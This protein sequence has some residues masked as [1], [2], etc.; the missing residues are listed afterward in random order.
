MK[1]LLQVIAAC[2]AKGVSLSVDDTGTG[3]KLKGNIAA[4]TSVEKETLRN[5]KAAVISLLQQ[6]KSV[7][8]EDI[9][10]A[11]P[12]ASWELSSAQ[13]RMWLLSQLEEGSAAYNIPVV[14]LFEGTLRQDCLQLAFLQL[15]E[16]H[17][18]LRAVFREDVAGEAKQH[19][20]SVEDAAF[21]IETHDL[22]GVDNSTAWVHSFVSQPFQ[23]SEGPL[24]RACICELSDSRRIFCLVMHHIISDGWSLDIIITELMLLYVAAC[25]GRTADMPALS[26]QYKDYATWQQRKIGTADFDAHRLYWTDLFSGELPVLSFP[27]DKPRPT[28]K[29]YKG[30]MV[31][32]RI[33]AHITTRLKSLLIAEDSTLFVGLLS[34]VNLLLF[35][36]TGQDDIITGTPVSGRSR[37]VL[38]NQVGLYLNTLALRTRLNSQDGFLSLLRHVRQM[39]LES[40]RHQDYPFDMLTEELRLEWDRSRNPLFDVMMILRNNAVS[41]KEAEQKLAGL[42]I[43]E[44]EGGQETF[45]KFDLS[46]NFMEIGD[47]I[48]MLVTYNS[49]IYTP[50]TA[51]RTGN[52]LIQLLDAAL[53]T[54]HTPISLL[55]YLTATEQEQLLVSFNNMQ[56]ACTADETIVDLFEEQALRTPT[57]TAVVYKEDTL[58][59][60][61]LNRRATLVAQ[62]L[63][64]KYQLGENALVGILLHRSADMIVAILGILKAGAAYVP[65]DPEYPVSRKAFILKDT[66]VKVLLTAEDAFDAAI[67]FTG[68]TFFISGL[69]AAVQDIPVTLLRPQQ[70]SLAYVIYTSGSTGEPKGVMITHRSLMDYCDGIRAV[71][72]IDACRTF[73]L[74][75]TIAADLGNTV[76]FPALLTG[77]ALQIYDNDALLT[78]EKIFNGDLDC[79]K[80]VPSHWM[81]LQEESHCYLP[82]K[83]LIF[84]G[85]QLTSNVVSFISRGN[86]TCEVYNHYGPSETTIGKLLKRVELRESVVH[87]PLGKPFCRSAFYIL[88]EAGQLQP[89]GVAGEICI[90]GDGL[91]KGYL[92]RPELTNTRFLP[93]PFME[94]ERMYKTGDVGRWL[95]NGCIEFMGRTDDQVK[96]RGYRIELGEIEAAIRRHADV[97]AAVVLTFAGSTGE[98]QLVAYIVDND[99]LSI[100]ALQ[101]WLSTLLPAYMIPAHFIRIPAMPL[102]LN[103]K[104]DRKRL[105]APEENN[106]VSAIEYIAPRTALEEQLANIWRGLLDKEKISVKDN[107]FLLGG[108][109]LKATRLLSSIRRE[110]QV[111]LPLKTLFQYMVLEEQAQL[112]A[113]AV[114]ETHQRITAAPLQEDYPL[115]SAQRRFWILSQFPDAAAAYHMP[116]IYQLQGKVDTM[117]LNA[118]FKGMVD[119]HE[120]LRT[121]FREDASGNIRQMIRP[122]EEIFPG[123][124]YEEVGEMPLQERIT[125]FVMQAF[126][127]TDGPLLRVA[128]Y[129]TAPDHFVLVY[130]MHHIISDG[131]SMGLLLKELLSRYYSL[132]SGAEPVPQALSLQYKDYAWWQ[133]QQLQHSMTSAR[134]FWMEQLSGELPVIN[135]PTDRLRPAIKT[136]Q[137]SVVNKRIPAAL[138]Q[139]LKG[140]VAMHDA[141]LFMGLLS[142]V[143]TLLY[144]YTGQQ[145]VITG[146]PVAGREHADLEDQLGLYLNTL[147]LR[148]QLDGQGSYLELLQTVRRITLDAYSHQSYPFEELVNDLKLPADLSRSP[149][150]DVM[151]ILQN[152]GSHR[153]MAPEMLGGVSISQ[154]DGDA[155]VRS[156]FDLTFSF[157]EVGQELDLY[158]EYNTDI[159]D[160]TTIQQLALHFI[161]LLDALLHAPHARIDLIDY[162]SAAEKKILTI[163]FN[164]TRVDYPAH[165]S[166]LQLLEKQAA[167]TPDAVALSCGDSMLTYRELHET[168]NRFAAFLHQHYR[169]TAGDLA[170]V[171]L[172]RDEWLIIALLGVLKTGAAYVPLDPDY[173]EE[174]IRYMMEDSRSLVLIDADVIAAFRAVANTFSAAEHSVVPASD[175]PAYLIYTSGSTGKPKGVVIT[176]LNVYTF[177]CWCLEEFALDEADVVLGVTSVC[178]DLSIF[179]IFYT[180]SSGKRLL[181]LPN[182][183][184]VPGCMDTE[185]RLLLNTVPGVVGQLLAAGTD[186]RAV[187]VLNMAGE[188]LPASVAFAD[189]LRQM[190]VRNLYGPSEDTTYSTVFRIGADQRI[191]IGR[192]IANTSVFIVSAAG[193]LQPIG[194]IGEI[195]ISGDGLA[196]GYLYRPELTAE[197]FVPNPFLPGQRMYKTGDL[198]RWLPDGNLEFAGRK[199]D[200]VKIRGYRIEPGEIATAIRKYPGVESAV[201]APRTNSQGEKF[202]A[203]YLVSDNPVDTQAL[204]TYL[205]KLL[206]H[207]MVP[208]CYM[209]LDTMPMTLNGKIDKK[210]LPAVEEENRTAIAFEAPRTIVEKQLA[211]IWHVLLETGNIGL[212]DNF[213]LHGGHSLK[214]IRLQ[215]QIHKAFQV[216]LDVPALFRHATLE[217]QARLIA[218]AAQQNYQTI[219]PLEEQEDYL[220][221][222]A[223]RRFWVLGQFP[224]AGAAYHMSG[225][226]ELDGEPDIA[227]LNH[228]FAALINRYEILRSIFREREDGEVRQVIQSADRVFRGIPVIEMEHQ[229]EEALAAA[230][231]KEVNRPFDLSA[232]PLLRTALYHTRDEKYVL[233]YVMHHII[234]DGWSVGIMLRE[235]ILLYNSFR[236]GVGVALSPLKLQYRDYAAWQQSRLHEEIGADRNWW[237]QQLSGSL[238]VLEMPVDAPRPALKTYNGGGVAMA[239]EAEVLQQLKAA[240]GKEG[241]TLFM[242]LLTAVYVLLHRYSG[243]EDIIIGSPVAGRNHADLEGQLGLFLNTLPLRMQVNPT[244][245]FHELLEQVRLLTLEAFAHQQYPFEELLDDLQ[246]APDLS[247]S[248]LFD[249]MLVLQNNENGFMNDRLQAG[250]ISIS[251]YRTRAVTKSRFDLTFSFVEV[252]GAL[253]AH[254]EYNS[255]IWHVATAERIMAHLYRIITCM[256]TAPDSI[257]GRMELLS[258][259]ETEQQLQQFN[260]TIT[261]YPADATISQLFAF[262][263][264]AK[265]DHIALSCNGTS[266][267]YAALNIL[268]NRFAH[269]LLSL[270]EFGKNSVVAIQLDKGIPMMTAILGVLKCGAAYMPVDP[271][272]PQERVNYMMADSGCSLLITEDMM[273]A[274]EEQKMMYDSHHPV[275]TAAAQDVAYVMYTSGSTGKPKG[276]MVEHRSV[277]RLVKG[278]QYVRLHDRDVLLSTGAVAFDATT[279]EYWGM[280]LN[281]GRLV[282]CPQ[283]T[284]SDTTYLLHLIRTEGVTMMWFTAG[285]FHQ[286]IEYNIDIF[287][288]L[289]TV[290][291]GGDRLSPLHVGK[292]LHAYPSLEI[293][294]GYGPTEN[295]T[296]SLTCRMTGDMK[297]IPIGRPISNSTVY[298]LDDH[299][300]LL[301]LGA[302]GE[303]CVGGD[304]LARGYIASPELTATRFI[305][306]PFLPGERIYKTGDLG[307]WLPDGNVCFL[308]RKDDQVKIRGYRIEPG[309]IEN[310]LTAYPQVEAALVMPV[311]DAAGDKML[312]AYLAGDARISRDELHQYLGNLLP[313]FML[314]DHYVFLEQFPLTANGKVDRHALPLPDQ[315]AAAGKTYVAPRNVTEEKLQGVWQEVL[316]REVISVTDD[317][318]LSGG[319]SLKANR[320]ILRIYKAFGVKM[321]IKELFAHPKLSEQAVWIDHAQG[322]GFSGIPRAPHQED[323]PLSAAQRRIWVLSRFD[324]ANIAYNVPFACV[325]EG[326]LD[327]AALIAALNKL[328]EKHESLRTV[329]RENADGLVRQV[330]L[331]AEQ[332]IVYPEYRDMRGNAAE[333][334]LQAAAKVAVPFDLAQGP[335]QRVYLW[336]LE[337][338]K[339]LLLYV[340]HHI[341]SDG[342]S[343]NVWIKEL[344]EQYRQH[345]HRPEQPA[346]LPLQYKDYAVWQQKQLD[347]TAG[348]ASRQYWLDQFSGDIP[349][350]DFPSDKIRPSV[351]TYR[352]AIVNTM[353]PV[354]CVMRLEALCLEHGATL[355]MGITAIVNAL[356]YRYTGQEDIILGTPVAGRLHTDLEEQIG[357]YINTLALRTQFS[358][359][360]SFTTL[361]TQVVNTTLAALEH[362]D[363]PF[364]ELVNNLP[365]RHDM[366]RNAL[367]DVMVTL[368]NTTDA[369]AAPATPLLRIIPYNDNSL[370]PGNKF[371]LTFSFVQ[372]VAGALQVGIVYNT[373]LYTTELITALAFHLEQLTQA[374]VAS[375]DTAVAMMDMLSSEEKNKVAFTFNGNHRDYPVG[376]SIVS[377]FQEQ[378]AVAGK[379]PALL[380]G[381]NSMSYD[382]LNTYANRMAAYLRENFHIGKGHMV[383]INLPRNEWLI[384]AVLGVLKTGAAYVPLDPAYPEER[385]AYILEDSQCAL[386]LNESAMLAFTETAETYSGQNPLQLPDAGD[387][388]YLIYTSGSTGK[389]KG[390][391]IEHRN[392]Y[393]FI[394]WCLE[395]FDSSAFDTVFGVTSIC[396]DLSVFEIF[397]TLICGKKLRILDNALSIPAW[398]R[399]T[400]RILLNTVPG[401]VAGLLS[402]NIDLS[403]VSLLNVAGEPVP[404]HFLQDVQLKRMQVRNLYGPS[405]DT[406]YSTIYR[407]DNANRVLIGKPISNTSVHILNA[408]G[409]LQPV[410]VRGEIC[411]S[412]AGLARGYKNQPA[413]TAEKFTDHP[414]LP[415]IRMYRTGDIGSWTED[416]NIAFWGRKDDQVKIRGFRIEPGEIEKALLQLAMVSDALVVAR[417]ERQGDK[418]LV[419]YIVCNEIPDI[420]AMRAELRKTLPDYMIPAYFV[421]LPHFPLTASGKKD[422]SKLPD[423]QSQLDEPHLSIAPRNET[424]ERLIRIWQ[425]LLGKERIGIRDNF[426]EC[427]GH[428]L[429]LMQMIAKIQQQFSVQ[430][431]IPQVFKDPYI[432]HISD[433]ITFMLD[434]QQLKSSI[435]QLVQIDI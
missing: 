316:G 207:Y 428:S 29:T 133:Q 131:W 94:G 138:L 194:V 339:W 338:N 211:E 102:T 71:T 423:H 239:I 40:F 420:P 69:Q 276:V 411:I 303:I 96:I 263:A 34:A 78:P 353:I 238:P 209:Q 265:P 416:G 39:T 204:Q 115:S 27:T 97:L 348:E 382:T 193:A 407:L 159:F 88:S 260:Q 1:A 24:L 363:Y 229:D 58:S 293:I 412:G 234:S 388:A 427:G 196:K 415:G 120:I 377:M 247:R 22:R 26:I 146:S 8:E 414:F 278:Q 298:I 435:D 162:L 236:T 269:F 180:L 347:Q 297:D 192:P 227:A 137:G 314:P 169:L 394:C 399:T 121:V 370:L 14:K 337:N 301:P 10:P 105:P 292:L 331:P 165:T 364:D 33:P 13:R 261:P 299:H 221:S 19:F 122:A 91:A 98:K 294:N 233:V 48:E 152:T 413:L 391:M 125:A 308:G 155:G 15:L 324:E 167:T 54:P 318:F 417:P 188:T 248:P 43:C 328:T 224:E 332:A 185:E 93:N 18:I 100:P 214:V 83:C 361:L 266:L 80:I 434:Q 17:E 342:W 144:R 262:Q 89:V 231:A 7:A 432:E 410:G 30:G 107:F 112:I 202:L 59:Y 189:S 113:N 371:D 64:G 205:A 296:F 212:K 379:Q 313:S 409:Q 368:N 77:G 336:Q 60:A 25:E 341:I 135:L 396:F 254:L 268:A 334:S 141:T 317:F 349:V 401:V 206:P 323:Y 171:M 119:R 85:E 62:Q 333:A 161:Q 257:I 280:L 362:Q 289:K 365:L 44:Y 284:L 345:G 104:I 56:D 429:K 351:K 356:L 81:A 403:A 199:D 181:L 408:A 9:L 426:F 140:T 21:V 28:V 383:G 400:E 354:E 267:T 274:F 187:K 127:L 148:V 35:R 51:D 110:F 79:I 433:Q 281:G 68:E 184:S 271:T 422:K 300:A 63:R 357:C 404:P 272:F 147:A 118:A 397:Y 92:N 226:Y 31:Y 46:F 101:H 310:A 270:Q 216:R 311:T 178:F 153:I 218:A 175:D 230:I 430:L 103:G 235:L 208:G 129:N 73:G 421:Q 201:V 372:D 61:E 232:G 249:V 75:S 84:G 124:V 157:A 319:H 143:Y 359:T 72:N 369:A 47:E 406:T 179:E 302:T 330:V 378:V 279:F 392:A 95:E 355:F 182:A 16:R 195:C 380:F 264:T 315:E 250:D 325:L 132:Q 168:S 86:P 366:G 142:A 375:P 45:N 312:V 5:Q 183:L 241:N 393:A 419:A 130:V 329:F 352:G 198:G 166:I 228:A 320:L 425:E 82:A 23:L 203:A 219:T 150:F 111:A 76:L 259:V 395:E 340:T 37:T 2:R 149:L 134:A 374:A 20:L 305:P 173:P 197:K 160:H 390:V 36:Y 385:I 154:W 367:F 384:I 256:A 225:I 220:L 402:E 145:D 174:R 373:D 343:M 283:D 114:K 381:D 109:S 32:K 321:T 275:N 389:P 360:A 386:V 128:L 176:H 50:S 252:N 244:L 66:Q 99:R 6:A 90:S 258:A 136:Y 156:K 243:Q 344:F 295:T 255:D 405:E 108:H 240:G 11:A 151:V 398:L 106:I 116:G 286:L 291:A 327:E 213:F 55:S 139:K 158:L 358:G 245:S 49:D 57:A 237:M 52:H 172:S 287:S 53:M 273:T 3:L 335:L 191:L 67:D 277:L 42:T 170:A 346:L 126:S 12:Q 376:S 350:L 326:E 253:Q 223:Q 251:A 215:S 285:W 4:L 163:T 309:E 288:G 217:E 123:I 282:L 306:H 41:H 418:S 65:I 38:E 200:Q 164:D 304:G 186:L 322:T 210:R 190:T 70:E 424:D 387:L 177:I 74:V 246:L 222:S 242:Q 87:E 290:L 431:S 117:A 307:K